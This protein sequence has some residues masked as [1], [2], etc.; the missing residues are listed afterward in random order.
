MDCCRAMPVCLQVASAGGTE[1]IILSAGGIKSMMLLVPIESMD[2]LSTGAESIILSAPPAES[3]ILS[4]L[5]AQ[6]YATL[7]GATTITKLIGDYDDR[8]FTTIVNS[9]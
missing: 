3:M 9:A 6:H 2:N 8:Q 7:T 5:F 1:S 4:V